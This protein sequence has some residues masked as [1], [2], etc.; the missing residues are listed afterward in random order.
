M[1]RNGPKFR[2]IPLTEVLFAAEGLDYFRVEFVL[3]QG[4][5]VELI[6][7]YD[8]GEREPSPRTE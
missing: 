3:K 1:A 4:K 7:L 8:N 5:A 6:G 2:L